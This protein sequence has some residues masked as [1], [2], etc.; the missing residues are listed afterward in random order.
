MGERT[1][2]EGE[3]GVIFI[4]TGTN[5]SLAMREDGVLFIWGISYAGQLEIPDV[6]GKSPLVIPD[7]KFRLMFFQLGKSS[8]LTKMQ[9]FN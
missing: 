4:A 2:K 7:L 9:V 1:T 3:P 8:L 6:D 5:N